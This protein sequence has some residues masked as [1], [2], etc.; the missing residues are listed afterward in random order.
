MVREMGASFV[1]VFGLLSSVPET[2][3]RHKGERS[4]SHKCML[5]IYS[6]EVTFGPPW[7][8]YQGTNH[9][10]RVKLSVSSPQQ[11]STEVESTIGGQWFISPACI[12]IQ[13]TGFGEL[14]GRGTCV[15]AGRVVCSE[16]TE[17]LCPFPHTLP[18]A[19]FPSG[20]S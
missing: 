9:I 19:S 16:G 18:S 10:R 8:G 11:N 15:D 17:A 5:M 7:A 3:H 1:I 4:G 20:C 13:R 12:K 6:N 14:P 2:V